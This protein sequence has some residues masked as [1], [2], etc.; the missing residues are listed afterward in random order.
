MTGLRIV[1]QRRKLGVYWI[2]YYTTWCYASPKNSISS[3]RAHKASCVCLG[4]GIFAMATTAWQA[5]QE[6]SS[7]PNPYN[8]IGNHPPASS[9]SITSPSVGYL[10]FHVQSLESPT[11]LLLVCTLEVSG[12][13]CED[14]IWKFMLQR[15]RRGKAQRITCQLLLL[16]A[17][18]NVVDYAYTYLQTALPTYTAMSCFKTSFTSSIA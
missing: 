11:F 17:N 1:V 8:A 18:P 16:C 5:C 9:L 13:K 10:D 4:R 7:N 2:A 3:I 12:V 15:R 6:E 14:A